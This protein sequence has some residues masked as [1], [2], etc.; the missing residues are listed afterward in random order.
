MTPAHVHVDGDVATVF[1]FEQAAEGWAHEDAAFF[2]GAI[3]VWRARN[4][5]D[6]A[7]GTGRTAA[8]SFLAAYLEKAPAGWGR[9]AGFVRL[10]SG[11]RWLM[12]EQRGDLAR[13]RPAAFRLL[14]LP[15]LERRLARF[16]AGS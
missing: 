10:V 16:A 15:A 7:V 8:R 11:I 14:V 1:D 2:L 12:M 9:A 4:P 6:L 5:H 3:D 13:R